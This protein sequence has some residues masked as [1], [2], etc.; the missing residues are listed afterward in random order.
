MILDEVDLPAAPAPEPLPGKSISLRNSKFVAIR[1][2]K[3]STRIFGTVLRSGESRSRPNCRVLPGFAGP[4]MNSRRSSFPGTAGAAL[5]EG[6]N[7]TM[8]LPYWVLLP[9][10][11]RAIGVNR[12]ASTKLENYLKNTRAKSKTVREAL[13][14]SCGPPPRTRAKK[15]LY[16]GEPFIRANPVAGRHHS[17]G[18]A[19]MD[20]Q[21]ARCRDPA[22]HHRG[23]RP[24]VKDE[25]AARFPARK[26][27]NWSTGRFPSSITCNFRSSRRGASGKF[28]QDVAWR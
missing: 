4:A 25:V 20:A 14:I 28:S 19:H 6:S 18:I 16:S 1:F 11:R 23:Q 5:N 17:R 9:T 21:N 12:A 26:S 8:R 2:A 7:G 15:R 13:R 24:T 27:P 10:G 3:N 22:R